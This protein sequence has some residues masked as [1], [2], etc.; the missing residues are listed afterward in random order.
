MN[1]NKFLARQFESLFDG[2]PWLD[3]TIMATL[4][5][6]SADKASAQPKTVPNSIWQI[7]HHMACWRQ[8]VLT[9][10][11][12]DQLQSPQ[13][14]FF[15]PVIDTSAKAW[16]TALDNLAKTQEEWL[17][18][19]EHQY[20]DDKASEK[21]KGTSYSVRDVIHGILQHDSYHLG[22]LV[23]LVKYNL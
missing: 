5:D 3:N 2:N 1:E 14:N 23:W 11:K 12:G 10:I 6:V 22:Q 18:F 19:L 7:V 13:D 4:K 17:S 21:Y 16:Q 8:H 9:R 15:S 20:D